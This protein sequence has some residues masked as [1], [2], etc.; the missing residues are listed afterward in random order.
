MDMRGIFVAPGEVES[1]N[2]ASF[3]LVHVGPRWIRLG[4]MLVSNRSPL[5]SSYQRVWTYRDCTGGGKS[6]DNIIAIGTVACSRRVR[7]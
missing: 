4:N 5:P 1:A 2:Q 3:E 7:V 6:I